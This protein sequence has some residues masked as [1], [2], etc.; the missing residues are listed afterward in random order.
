M[1]T[2]V[3]LTSRYIEHGAVN[4][5]FCVDSDVV[6]TPQTICGVSDEMFVTA[7]VLYTPKINKYRWEIQGLIVNGLDN[8]TIKLYSGDTKLAEFPVANGGGFLI[9]GL[10]ATHIGDELKIESSSPYT[11]LL[12]TIA[13][14]KEGNL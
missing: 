4:Y 12:L 11:S 1:A 6:D 3:K 2:T 5:Q 8:K 14:K 7:G 10:R 9:E 13:L